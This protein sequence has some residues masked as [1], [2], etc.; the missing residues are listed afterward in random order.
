MA[1]ESEDD[2]ISKAE[3]RAKREARL[4]AMTPEE[5]A[6]AEARRAEKKAARKAE[7]RAAKRNQ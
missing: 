3:K 5:R 2:G 4:A 6:K 7:R 1:D